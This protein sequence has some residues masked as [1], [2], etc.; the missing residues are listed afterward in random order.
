MIGSASMGSCMGSDAWLNTDP[1][2]TQEHLGAAVLTPFRIPSGS[3]ASPK[4]WQKG[5]GHG[6]Q[7]TAVGEYK[8]ALTLSTDVKICK[9]FCCPRQFQRNRTWLPPPPCI[10][11][12][13]EHQEKE[14]QRR[15]LTKSPGPSC[16]WYARRGH[17]DGIWGLPPLLRFAHKTRMR[18]TTS[19]KASVLTR[20]CVPPNQGC[21][22]ICQIVH[23]HAHLARLGV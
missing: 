4:S 23:M 1:M 14:S 8:E 10:P 3:E 21:Q 17:A 9:P 7:A 16:S 6:K 11:R 12:H 15:Q 13:R 2:M 5:P 18:C 19:G 20:P 22:R